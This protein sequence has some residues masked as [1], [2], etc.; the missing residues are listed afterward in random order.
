[1]GIVY[2]AENLKLKHQVALK[3]LSAEF[4]HEV[5]AKVLE[6]HKICV[7]LFPAIPTKPVVNFFIL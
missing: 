6:L 3:L 2:K 7:Y 5:D 1:M 4:T